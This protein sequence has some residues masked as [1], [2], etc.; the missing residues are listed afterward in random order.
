MSKRGEYCGIILSRQEV[1]ECNPAVFYSEMGGK[2]GALVPV[3]AVD[4]WD[5]VECA[6]TECFDRLLR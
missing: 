2:K 6:G 4:H 3:G 5:L 1:A